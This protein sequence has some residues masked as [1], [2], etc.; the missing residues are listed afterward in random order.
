MAAP[1]ANTTEGA[2]ESRSGG[3]DGR[4][5]GAPT[6]ADAAVWALQVQRA[7]ETA[8]AMASGAASRGEDLPH[9]NPNS[10]AES[11][12]LGRGP[13]GTCGLLLAMWADALFS[14]LAQPSSLFSRGVS[15]RC[16]GAHLESVGGRAAMNGPRTAAAR[17]RRRRGTPRTAAAATPARC[18]ARASRAKR[19]REFAALLV[20]RF[21]VCTWYESTSRE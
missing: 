9:H 4:G 15:Q 21:L 1:P 18:D 16:A 7:R 6:V 20:R 12:A 2:A 5:G 3:A 8:W 10:D 17:A 19:G 14:L 13:N 11:P